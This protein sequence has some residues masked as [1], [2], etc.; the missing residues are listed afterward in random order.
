MARNARTAISPRLAT[1]TSENTPGGYYPAVQR[2][3]TGLGPRT[4]LA[5]F[6]ARAHAHVEDTVDLGQGGHQELDAAAAFD[7]QLEV[8]GGPQVAPARRP[9]GWLVMTSATLKPWVVVAASTR[10]R[11]AW[12]SR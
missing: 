11:T 5:L 3:P 12:P 7:G 9:A 6:L 2:P 8:D 4:A 10:R 1:S